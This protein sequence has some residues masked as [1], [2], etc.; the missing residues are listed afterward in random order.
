[1]SL[2][3]GTI[4]KLAQN[5]LLPDEQTAINV[6]W[7]VLEDAVGSGPLAVI[8]ILA[9]ASN[10]MDS[11]YGE[12]NGS[13]ADTLLSTIVEVWEVDGPTGDLT[14]VG[15]EATTWDGL[16]TNDALPNGVAGITTIKTTDTDV[17]G[18]KFIPGFHDGAADDNNLVATPL[19]QLV[20][21]ALSWAAGWTDANDVQFV[22]GVYSYTKN[23]FLMA[24]GTTITNAIVGY[25][26]R[27]KPGVGS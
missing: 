26:R 17:T 23:N 14:P 2:P 25:Q 20:D 1:M 18:R 15:D 5:I 19:S 7:V 4:L 21:F 9:A 8:D 22:S 24:T 27:R 12:V 6:F 3:E 16:S 10:Y 11:L 13:L